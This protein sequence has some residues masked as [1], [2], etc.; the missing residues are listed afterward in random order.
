MT[1][2]QCKSAYVI[3]PTYKHTNKHKITLLKPC[4]E[5]WKRLIIHWLSVRQWI[6]ACCL[7]VSDQSGFLLIACVI[8]TQ[9]SCQP[10]PLHYW[11][12]VLENHSMPCLVIRPGVVRKVLH[13][14]LFNHP[15]LW[16]ERGHRLYN[17][18]VVCP[19]HNSQPTC[20][21]GLVLCFMCLILYDQLC[22]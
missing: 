17:P 8:I 10:I 21:K 2:G 7:L 6:R 22:G 12:T 13:F 5:Y 20:R 11:A 15:I 9:H 16:Y 3:M 14:F 1:K 4:K 19:V 18:N